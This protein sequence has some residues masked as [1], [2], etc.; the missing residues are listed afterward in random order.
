MRAKV[1]LSL[2]FFLEVFVLLSAFG[3]GGRM[4]EQLL[5][6]G[7]LGVRPQGGWLALV[8]SLELPLGMGAAG[9]AVAAVAMHRLVPWL[10]SLIL[11]DDEWQQHAAPL[12]AKSK[13]Y[14]KLFTIF[15]LPFFLTGI[16][17]GFAGGSGLARAAVF[18]LEPSGWP[19]IFVSLGLAAISVYLCALIGYFLILLMGTA[20][21]GRERLIQVFDEFPKE[22]QVQ[23]GLFS[24]LLARPMNAISNRMLGT[25]F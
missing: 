21:V 14:A 12:T 19:V 22:P 11:S 1:L 23:T 18:G 4:G 17:L 2:G 8:L 6:S 9:A 13:L 25:N 3:L 5:S 15:L 7:A 24:R 10:G 20:V 16:V